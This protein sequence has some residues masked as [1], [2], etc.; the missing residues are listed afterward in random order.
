MRYKSVPK[1]L[2]WD[3]APEEKITVIT[4]L[5]KKMIIKNT[6]TE[7]GYPNQNPVE[8]LGVKSL[9]NTVKT[10]IN[11]IGIEKN[12]GHGF[13]NMWLILTIFVLYQDLDRKIYIWYAM[14]V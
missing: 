10:I 11:R 6:W 3:L 12:F 7:T 4:D 8:A 1:Y 5:N 13:P 14:D 9:K 2:Y